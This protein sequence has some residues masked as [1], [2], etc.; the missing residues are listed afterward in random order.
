M[1]KRNE[2]SNRATELV[3]S[4]PA[5]QAYQVG[6]AVGSLLKDCM[7][8]GSALASTVTV[9]EFIRRGQSAQ[10]AVDAIIAAAR[11]ARKS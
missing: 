5:E 11:S 7:P 8:T 4:L 6:A 2:L 1:T 3:A 10:Q 9:A